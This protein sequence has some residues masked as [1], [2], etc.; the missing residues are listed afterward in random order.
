M[1][2]MTRVRLLAK[3]C[4]AI[5]AVTFGS[6]FIKKW[7]A[8]IRALIVPNSATAREEASQKHPNPLHRKQYLYRYPAKAMPDNASVASSTLRPIFYGN[9]GAQ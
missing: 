6:V 8:P 5:S 9:I 2:F 4:S 7:L 3:T 1:M